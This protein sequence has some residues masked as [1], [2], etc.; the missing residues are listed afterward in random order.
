MVEWFFLFSQR[1]SF[2]SVKF[3]DPEISMIFD[4]SELPES[5]LLLI[6]YSQ[7]V[8]RG[9]VKFK[10]LWFGIYYLYLQLALHRVS[11]RVECFGVCCFL[12]FFLSQPY[13]RPYSI[14]CN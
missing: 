4:I 13:Y 6:F 10:S 9:V 12:F 1:E 5:N 8:D 14:W 2:V 11:D 7:N 3:F